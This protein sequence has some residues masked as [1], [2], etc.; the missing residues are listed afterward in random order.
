LGYYEP[1]DLELI[2][3]LEG[4]CKQGRQRVEE[5][6]KSLSREKQD[7]AKWE[8]VLEL[9]RGH[10]SMAPSVNSSPL[11]IE[12]APSKTNVI[13]DVIRSAGKP[14]TIPEI[15]YIVEAGISKSAVYWVVSKEKIADRMREDSEGRISLVEEN[16]AKDKRPSTNSGV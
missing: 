5:A 2:A 8:A 9:E 13:R 11:K 6:E 15:I 4:R 12:K 16:I 3:M 14:L 1:V 10:A 7:L